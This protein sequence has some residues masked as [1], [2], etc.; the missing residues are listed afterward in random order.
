MMMTQ[1]RHRCLFRNVAHANKTVWRHWR[2]RHHIE[3]PHAFAVSAHA[4]IS[5]S[6]G[7]HLVRGNQVH[8]PGTGDTGDAATIPDTAHAQ[9]HQDVSTLLSHT[10]ITKNVCVTSTCCT[11]GL[12]TPCLW[13]PSASTNPCNQPFPGDTPS[14]S[15]GRERQESIGHHAVN[16]DIGRPLVNLLSSTIVAASQLAERDRRALL[17]TTCHRKTTSDADSTLSPASFTV[18]N[19]VTSVCNAK[20]RSSVPFAK[21]KRINLSM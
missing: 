14:S 8:R 3:K 1:I 9:K 16:D 5:A 11:S 19:V 13:E 2:R 12:S 15:A 10:L 20:T 17:S 7:R 6:S 18:A 21:I 4:I